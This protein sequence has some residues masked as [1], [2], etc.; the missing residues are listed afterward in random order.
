MNWPAVLLLLCTALTLLL[1]WLTARLKK[2]PAKYHYV[3]MLLASA[4]WSAMAGMENM[5]VAPADKLL[6]AKLAWLGIVAV[7]SYWTMFVW[8]Y[9]KGAYQSPTRLG[10]AALLLMPLLT[11]GI[12]L[13]NDYHHW[14]YTQTDPIGPHLGA[15]IVYQHGPWFYICALFMYGYMAL[16]MLVIINALARASQLHRRHYL[17]LAIAM[18]IPWLANVAYVTGLFTVFNF[19]PTPFSFLIMGTV[20]YWLIAHRRLFDLLPIAHDV[21]IDAI[22]DAVLVINEAK[23]IAQLNQAAQALPD[24]PPDALGLPLAQLPYLYSI[25]PSLWAQHLPVEVELNLGDAYYDLRSVTL[26]YQ[27]HPIGLLLVLRNITHHKHVHIELQ[28]ALISFEDQLES[29]AVLHQQL[30]EAAIRDPLTGLHNRRFLDEI[31]PNLLAS[32]TR[33]QQTL[34]LVMIDLDHFKLV[35]DQY[36]HATGDL[37]LRHMAQLLQ[38]LIRESDFLFRLGGEEFLILMP[39]TSAELAWQQSNL[40]R[41]QLSLSPAAISSTHDLAVTFSAG[42]SELAGEN[43][44][45]DPALLR[46]DQALYQAKALGR[47]RSERL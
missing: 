34:A 28:Q 32:L 36:G 17:G 18:S 38:Q 9:V 15:A 4:W 24:M 33:K 40:W 29:N 37:V 16:S 12:A 39:E 35:N 41:T 26:Y 19:D 1:A 45:L 43:M 42:I 44:Q 23:Q 2:F 25:L 10:K 5:V 31:T 22:P 30:H 3:C 14:L 20:F 27:Q 6:F 46:A 21:L 8:S 13:S 7:P 47:N 11:V